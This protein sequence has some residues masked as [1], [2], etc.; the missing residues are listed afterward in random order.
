MTKKTVAPDAAQ[1]ARWLCH[2]MA[3]PIATLLTA[4]ELMSGSNDPEINDLIV[5][6]IRKL[7][8]RLRLVRMAMGSQSLLTPAALEKLLAE[9][10]PDTPVAL[11]ITSHSKVP[12]SL[13][14]G[15]A[16]V[17]SDLDHKAA[18]RLDDQGAFWTEGDL[19]PDHAA[20][21][22]AGGATMS[23]RGSMMA[24]VAAQ[25][26]A[27]GWALAPAPSGL[28]FQALSAALA[29]SSAESARP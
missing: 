5:A 14:A 15:A 1:V 17:L 4:S 11:A 10:M 16:L 25:A 29:E 12:G 7:S 18:I 9:A 23:P 13:L 8:A 28:T 24:L 2:D 20:A 26:K 3:T 19:L 21:A 22:L 27:S 6:A